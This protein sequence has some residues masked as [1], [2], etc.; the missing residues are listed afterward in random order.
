MTLRKSVKKALFGI[1]PTM[2][3]KCANFW[4]ALQ[5]IVRGR[6]SVPNAAKYVVRGLC[7]GLRGKFTYYGTTVYFPNPSAIFRLTCEKGAWEPE[8]TAWLCRLASP[9]KLFIDVGANIGLSSIAVLREVADSR[10]LSFEPSPNSLPYLQ[11][12]LRE[13]R[14][15]DRWELV[16]KAAGDCTSMAQFFMA[17]PIYAM[18]DSMRDT[19]QVGERRLVTVPMTTVDEE[20][21]RLGYPAVSVMKIDVEGA[22]WK[23]LQGARALVT[24]ERPYIVLEWSRINLAA[25]ETDFDFVLRYADSN[26]YDVFVLQNLSPVSSLH[27]LQLHMLYTEMFLLIPRSRTCKKNSQKD[28]SMIP[29]L[30]SADMGAAEMSNAHNTVN[31]ASS[32]G[33]A[34]IVTNRSPWHVSEL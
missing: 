26:Q 34:Q 17:D 29:N 24:R 11:R 32:G 19:G 6:I 15:E 31:L 13:S 3:A 12:T 33:N 7:P 27:V 8:V 28:Y 30:S 23:V 21:C 1:S 22:E 9:G 5:P 10:V 18:W 25:Y 16:P 20:W 14:M 4:D 2:G